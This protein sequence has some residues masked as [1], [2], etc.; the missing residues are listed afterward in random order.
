MSKILVFGSRDWN[1]KTIV[2]DVLW[3]LKLD[4]ISEVVHGACRGADAI[5]GEI[6]RKFEMPVSEYPADWKRLG[7]KAGP[8]RN[9]LMLN[10]NPGISFAV[11][12]HDDLAGSRGSLD[13][14][15]RCQAK[16]LKVLLVSH[17]DPKGSWL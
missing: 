15:R 2:E 1:D 16:C 14:K 11:A 17:A 8:I 6:A 13:M 3:R 7:S 9:Q 10:S 5:A 4:G 12:F